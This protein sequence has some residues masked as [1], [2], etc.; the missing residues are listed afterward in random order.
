MS[1]SRQDTP[2]RDAAQR[3]LKKFRLLLNNV[4]LVVS[5]EWCIHSFS[6]PY[7]N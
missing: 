2:I 7:Y 1:Y 4:K 3:F 6:A 5:N